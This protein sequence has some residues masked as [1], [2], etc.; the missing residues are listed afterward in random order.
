MWLLAG[1]SSLRLLV[2]QPHFLAV[3]PKAALRSQDYVN[4]P[5]TATYC[6]K[7]SHGESASNWDVTILDHLIQKWNPLS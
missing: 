7:A 1:F 6:I 3:W 4:V 2:E 5:D